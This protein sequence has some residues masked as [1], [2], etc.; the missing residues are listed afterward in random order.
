MRA[1]LKTFVVN[2][3]L[4]D[5]SVLM[6]YTKGRTNVPS[7]KFEKLYREEMRTLVLYRMMVLILFLDRAKMTNVLDTAP[8]LFAKS[9]DVKSSKAVLLSF[10]RNFLSSEGDFIKHLS[11]IGLKVSYVQ[12]PI[13]ELGFK[14]SN[15]ATDLRDGSRLTRLTEIV[16]DAH[17]KSVMKKLR[18]PSVSRLQKMHN[19]NVAFSRL[20]EQGIHLPA[21]INAHHIVDAHREMV[22]KL[23]W[24]VVAHSCVSK[25]L[26]GGHV[27]LEIANVL[28]SNQAR[29][30]V[31]GQG[32][33]IPDKFSPLKNGSA[34]ESPE[35]T[36]KNL[37][38]R[39]CQ[40]VCNNYGIQLTDFTSS[41]ADGR[42]LCYLVHYYHPGIIP[43]RD[44]LPTSS[45][46]DPELSPDQALRNQRS[47]SLMVARRISDL[48][49]IPRM[50]PIMDTTNPP[51]E[52]SMLL[53]LTYLCSR[54]MES[55]KEIFA[56][57]LIQAYYRR[58]K[59]KI[60]LEKKEAAA[61]TI[62]QLWCKHKHQYYASLERRYVASVRVLEAFI[63]THK[64][65]L[66]RMKRI[67]LA[68]EGRQ[69]AALNIQ[70]SF[71]SVLRLNQAIS[72]IH[73]LFLAFIQGV[74]CAFTRFE[75]TGNAPCSNPHPENFPAIPGPNEVSRGHCTKGVCNSYSIGLEVVLEP[76]I[77]SE[78]IDGRQATSEL[79]SWNE[80]AR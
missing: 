48:G 39:W 28:R 42:A 57:I 10:C 21:D 60:L 52:K 78:P 38:F 24:A 49:G 45:E 61:F 74:P 33:C 55:S 31:Q 34:N 18:L 19:V 40:A 51:D 25:L 50:L 12:D 20:K 46:S 58:Y 16:T 17:F 1:T 22:L 67:R 69:A 26:Q 66:E 53:C 35:Q 8:R 70:V 11:R 64:H 75:Q 80:S 27:E 47:N 7:G 36:M 77:V 65:S 41:F 68:R 30:K 43:L 73:V 79:L 14:V 3:V 56:T 63:L 37:L 44:I 32:L 54:L 76:K 13:D 5:H 62:Y 23:M 71:A 4:T 59:E 72:F 2:R 6:K 9:S 15:L 29:R